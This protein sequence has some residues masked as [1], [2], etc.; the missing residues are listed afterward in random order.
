[1]KIQELKQD[2]KYILS[3]NGRIDTKTAPIFQ[4]K[5][6]EI[7]NST[8]ENN[9]TINLVLDFKGIDYVSSAGLRAILYVQKRINSMSGS[10][11]ILDNVNSTVMEV[12]EMTGFTEFLTIGTQ[13]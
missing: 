1:M 3:I 10:T 7:I 6:E 5:L 4:G 9:E 8:K 11:M 12:L 13:I 2:G